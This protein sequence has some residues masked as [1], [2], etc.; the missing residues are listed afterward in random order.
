[1]PLE[2]PEHLLVINSK[3]IYSLYKQILAGI[4][5]ASRL[6][7]VGHFGR[8]RLN[9][10]SGLSKQL[11]DALPSYQIPKSGASRISLLAFLV[12]GGSEP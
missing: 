11:Q 5:P 9:L 4:P 12:Y 1:M 8:A 2:I 7:V 3:I 10:A 6:C